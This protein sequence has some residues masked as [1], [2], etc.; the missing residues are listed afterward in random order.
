MKPYRI[1]LADDHRMFRAGLKTLIERE[2]RFAVIDE[3]SDGADLLE[4]LKGSKCDLIVMDLSMPR[5]DG[6]K[7]MEQIVVRYSR[8]KL[9]VLTMQ[10]D[11][12]FFRD[13]MSLGA[14]GYLLKDDA[15]EQ[16]V[17]AMDVLLDGGQFFS[18]SVTRLL[19][20]EHEE[21]PESSQP[22]V[23]MPAI[24]VLTRREREVLRLIAAG[25]ANKN[26]ARQLDI[27]V[28]TVEVH[29]SNLTKKLGVKSTAGL[30]RYTLENAFPEHDF[31]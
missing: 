19:K 26:I 27:S 29:R 21:Q 28:R 23:S 22:A 4:K 9:L 2:D 25:L 11:P 17:R 15:F 24:D 1:I 31:S 8:I 16:L 13:A 6:L 12:A 10:K 14:S 3:A 5:M 7:A 18:P 20:E 30:V